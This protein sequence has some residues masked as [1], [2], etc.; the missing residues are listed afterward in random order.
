MPSVAQAIEECM[1]L[2]REWQPSPNQ[3]GRPALQALVRFWPKP[4][5]IASI[6]QQY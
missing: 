5:E 6:N 1:E 2:R 4:L 3:L